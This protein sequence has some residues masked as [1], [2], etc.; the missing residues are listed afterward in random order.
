M[1]FTETYR[2]LRWNKFW[3]R[4]HEKPEFLDAKPNAGHFAIA[5]ITQRCNARIVTQNIDRLHPITLN[6]RKERL[7]EV[8]GRLGLY[9]W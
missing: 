9:K 1:N 5:Q 8:H 4:T 6:V 7:I 2:I 3:L